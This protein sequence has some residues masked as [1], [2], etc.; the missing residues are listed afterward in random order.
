MHAETGERIPHASFYTAEVDN[1]RRAAM[2]G[3]LDALQDY[4]AW[5]INVVEMLPG[6]HHYSWFD[7]SRKIKT[8]KNYWQRHWESLYDISQDDTAENNMF[9]G[10]SWK[11]VSDEDIEELAT[12]LAENMGG[13]IFHSREDFENPTPHLTLNRAQPRLMLDDD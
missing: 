3:N 11:E 7:L 5:F 9:F 6:V 4:Q 13:W 2:T 10:K 1:V 8:Y 12:K